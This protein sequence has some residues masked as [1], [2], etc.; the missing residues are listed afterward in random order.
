MKLLYTQCKA[1]LCN[2]C[3][4]RYEGWVH[5]DNTNVSEQMHISETILFLKMFKLQRITCNLFKYYTVMSSY[6]KE[7]NNRVCACAC[8]CV[9]G[10]IFLM[11][12]Q[13][14]IV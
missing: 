12:W 1:T 5:G 4:V 11:H 6:R 7:R 2:H 3:E 10:F 13:I 8:V 14:K 9:G